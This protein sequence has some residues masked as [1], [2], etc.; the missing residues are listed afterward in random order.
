MEEAG[1]RRSAVGDRRSAGA[2][3]GRVG[4]DV[5][6]EVNFR[7]YQRQRP[8]KG[9]RTSRRLIPTKKV[10]AAPRRTPATAQPAGCL[11]RKT[12]SGMLGPNDRLMNP[13]VFC[14]A[15]V[16]AGVG[17]ATTTTAQTNS[18]V[19]SIRVFRIPTAQLQTVDT[20]APASKTGLQQGEIGSHSW[21]V[22]TRLADPKV[23]PWHALTS[24]VNSEDEDFRLAD[25]RH[26][27]WDLI[28]PAKVPADPVARVFDSVFRPE[29]FRV[30]RN[31]TV[32]CSILT[33]VK[34]KNPMCL[35]SPLFLNVSW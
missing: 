11:P 18:A 23:Q 34:R 33:A 15:L 30:G 26:L 3:D 1:N 22:E 4:P 10:G 20:K 21:P 31:T 25:G 29:E 32:S 9:K 2:R 6:I 17:M 13:A 19:D 16:M 12:A 7:P 35:L 14:R 8:R 27:D 28:R 5:G 24:V